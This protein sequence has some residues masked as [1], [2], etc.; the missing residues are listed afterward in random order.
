MSATVRE[1]PD[2]YERFF[3]VVSHGQSYL[4]IVYLLL[5]FPAGLFYFIFLITGLSLGLGLAIVWIGIPI[6]LLVLA[7]WWGMLIFEREMAIRLLRVEIAPMS[8]DPN[9]PQGMW[10]RLKTILSNPVTWKGLLYLLARF[11]LGILAFVIVVTWLSLAVGLIS[12]P[13]VYTIVP[14]YVGWG[15][16]ANISDALLCAVVGIVIGIAGMHLMNLVSYIYGQFARLMLGTSPA[17]TADASVPAE[18]PPQQAAAPARPIEV[19]V[20]S[21]I[22]PSSST[23]A[24]PARRRRRAQT[25]KADKQE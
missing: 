18:L 13:L 25:E 9:P 15:R 16:V 1:Q 21:E 8:R 20:V 14:L 11:P 4:N 12:A 22:E 7:G 17:L 23:P 5:S 24:A 3:G 2:F 6:L 10:A 19:G